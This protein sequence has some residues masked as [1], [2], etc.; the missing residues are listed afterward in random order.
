MELVTATCDNLFADEHLT[1]SAPLNNG[2]QIMYI[3]TDKLIPYNNQPFKVLD[4]ES[5][6]E[7]EESVSENGI[8]SPITVRPLPDGKY[9]IL[10]G[11][12]RTHVADKL[13]L[14]EVPAIVKELDD[15]DAAVLLVD[16]NLHREKILPSEKAFAYKLKLD[17]LKDKAHRAAAR[18]DGRK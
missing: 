7:L 13:G 9:E 6:T 15:E 11:H 4:D 16:S 5:M 17:T 18:R 3:D 1:D 2:A 10:S 14:A 12:R 8:M